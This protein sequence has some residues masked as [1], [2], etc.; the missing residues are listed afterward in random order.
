MLGKQGDRSLLTSTASIPGPHGHSSLVWFP[1]KLWAKL[2]SFIYSHPGVEYGMFDIIL[3]GICSNIPYIN[4]IMS[5][6]II[7]PEHRKR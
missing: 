4:H 2:K 1:G 5:H 7:S 6:K 3:T